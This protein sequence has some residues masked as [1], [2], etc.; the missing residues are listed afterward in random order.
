MTT[1]V[2]LDP[3]QWATITTTEDVLVSGNVF[4]IAFGATKPATSDE[5]HIFRFPTIVPK[6]SKAYVRAGGAMGSKVKF[7][8]LGSTAVDP[9][10]IPAFSETIAHHV[11]LPADGSALTIGGTA[12]GGAAPLTYSWVMS[13]GSPVA[14]NPTAAT[15][16]VTS[17]G[18]YQLTVTD[19]S[20]Y[21]VSTNITV[22][23]AG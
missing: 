17:A 5:G 7:S 3:S 14:G 16:D 11:Q 20:G 12:T 9:V 13:D 2:Y 1:T 19:A 22:T 4:E 10:S 18:V 8:S 6:G 23:S 21:H 15:I